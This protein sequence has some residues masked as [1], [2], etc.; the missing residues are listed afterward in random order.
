MKRI[1]GD[2]NLTWPKIVIMAI[3]IGIYTGTSLLIPITRDTSFSDL[4]A[5]FEVWIL[6]GIFIIMNS[7]TAKESALKCFIFFLISQPIVYFVQ[8][9]V[10]GTSLFWTYY[11]P[12]FIWTILCLPMGY[13]GYYMKKNKWWGLLILAPIL[14]LLGY[15]YYY[16][17]DKV[18]FAFPR[19]L[20]T[21]LFCVITGL[22]YPLAIF[23]DKKIKIA[24]VT[25]SALI[26]IV[27]TVLG[28]GSKPVYKAQVFS[29]NEEHPFDNTC[30]VI[31]GDDTYGK[32]SIVYIDSIQD[33]MVQG[34]FI[35]EGKTYFVLECPNGTKKTFDISIRQ[36]TYDVKERTE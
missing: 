5:T 14:V 3:I 34:D 26:I 30:S 23:E 36:S 32:M 25:I 19:H 13:I 27:F 8:D 10:E 31:I 20:L 12:W 11:K 6:F 7:K 28:L 21:I 4:G 16:Y 9:L 18:M 1:F 2:I 33:Y 17:L 24:G 35:K 22:V 15:Q 29:N